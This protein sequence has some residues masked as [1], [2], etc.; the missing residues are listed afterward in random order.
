MMVEFCL[1]A[2]AQELKRIIQSYHES[3]KEDP[4]F[5]Y[6]CM[7]REDHKDRSYSTVRVEYDVLVSLVT[8]VATPC[9]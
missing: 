2:D 1:S 4:H 8:T 9:C 5:P 6:A 3:R 7:V